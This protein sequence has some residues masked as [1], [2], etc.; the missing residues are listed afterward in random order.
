ML[1]QITYQ[2]AAALAAIASAQAE[3]DLSEMASVMSEAGYS[4]DAHRVETEDGWWLSLFRITGKN[5]QEEER[6]TRDIP[7]LVQHGA[8]M[9]A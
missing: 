5:G 9:D 7:V 3:P 8:M 4:W 1:K 6:V 2:L